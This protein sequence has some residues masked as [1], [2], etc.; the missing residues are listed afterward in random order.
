MSDAESLQHVPEAEPPAPVPVTAAGIVL[1]KDLHTHLWGALRSTLDTDKVALSALW[2]CNLTGL[3]VIATAAGE[4]VPLAGTVAALGVIDY[5]LY[6]I[7][8]SSRREVRRLVSLLS[9]VYTDH[10]LGAYFDQLREEYYVE[11]YDLRRQLCLVL[12]G[13]A[14]VLGLAFG[15]S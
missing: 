11:R 14:V 10:G 9:D 13:I 8:E 1:L 6:R 2:L 4:P 5:F 7:F 12:F 3:V 15:L